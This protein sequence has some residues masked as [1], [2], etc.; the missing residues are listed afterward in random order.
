[1]I[2][3]KPATLGQV[4]FDPSNSQRKTEPPRVAPIKPD[5]SYAVKTLV[6]DNAVRVS[7]PGMEKD[8]E[9][10]DA[11]QTCAVKPGENQFPIVLPVPPR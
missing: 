1:M 7:F 3:G 6:G 5:G 10:S 9:I 4:S 11:D 8:R 2:R